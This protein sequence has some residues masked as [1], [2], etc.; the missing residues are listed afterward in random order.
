[1]NCEGHQAFNTAA[2]STAVDQ[3]ETFTTEFA[4]GSTVQGEI[5][6]DTVSLGGLVATGQAVVA[7]SR[8]RSPGA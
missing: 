2:S 3:H 1:M 6:T 5:F 8:A 7:A 4:D